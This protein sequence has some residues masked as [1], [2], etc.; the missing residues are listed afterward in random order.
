MPAGS[1]APSSLPDANASSKGAV[2]LKETVA[3]PKVMAIGG[4]SWLIANANDSNVRFTSITYDANDIIATANVT[5]PDG[6]SGVWTTTSAS[7][8]GVLIYTVT[9]VGSTTKTVTCTVTR[10]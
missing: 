1:V 8:A 7:T 4:D 5:W 10:D 9:W 6:T 3:N 2:T